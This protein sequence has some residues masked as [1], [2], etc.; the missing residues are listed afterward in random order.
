MSYDKKTGTINIATDDPKDF[1]RDMFAHFGD[2]T[3][4]VEEDIKSGKLPQ[5]KPG[6]SSNSKS[7]HPVRHQA[8]GTT[9]KWVAVVSNVVLVLTLGFLLWTKGMPSDEEI[10]IFMILFTAP[11][12]SLIAL[13]RIGGNNWLGLYFKRKALEEQKRI[14]DLE[15]T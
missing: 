5:A 11:I 10:S 9:M 14:N 8:E 3:R 2:V 13:L 4:K 12:L 7:P 15:G 1:E 6:T